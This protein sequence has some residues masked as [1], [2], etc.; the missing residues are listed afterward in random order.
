[1]KISREIGERLDSVSYAGG[2]AVADRYGF[3][4]ERGERNLMTYAMLTRQGKN[5]E[6]HFTILQI[7]LSTK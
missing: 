1:M 7:P 3:R 5:L 6:I 4:V 2:G